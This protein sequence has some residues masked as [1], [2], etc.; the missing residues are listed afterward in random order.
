MAMVRELPVYDRPRERLIRFGAD[1]LSNAE[2]LALFIRNGS[3]QKS[4]LDLASEVLNIYRDGGLSAMRNITVNE[5]TAV[6]GIGNAKAAEIVAAVELGKRLAKQDA[7]NRI[8]VS[9]PEDAAAYAMHRLR[10]EQKENF[11]LILL[12]VKNHILA[13][14]VISVGSLTASIVHPRE[15]FKTAVQYSAAAIILVHNHPS[16]DPSPS[17]EDISITER[18][19]KCSKLMDIPVLDH[20]IIGDDRFVSLKERGMMS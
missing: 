8:I 9:R 19:V 4:A 20:I 10:F 13:M 12:Y 5:L 15:V 11:A 2:L 18:L 1:S 6:K 7:Q 16:G 17:R 3:K 14:P